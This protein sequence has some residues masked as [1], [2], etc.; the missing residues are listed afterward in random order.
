VVGR[1]A[2]AFE[3]APGDAVR[4]WANLDAMH[5]FDPE[6]ETSVMEGTA[7]IGV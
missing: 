1:V 7:A 5:L 3:H 6:T 2:P 4:L